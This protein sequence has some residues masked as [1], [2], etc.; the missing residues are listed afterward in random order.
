MSGANQCP[1]LKRQRS[2]ALNATM[3]VERFI[4]IAP[5]LT[6]TRSIPSRFATESAIAFQSAAIIATRTAIS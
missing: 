3:I 2:W 6:T 5:T 4:A 1:S